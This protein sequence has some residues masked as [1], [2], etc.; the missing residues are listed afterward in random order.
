MN[1]IDCWSVTT[2]KRRAVRKWA[3]LR[4]AST[5]AVAS[6]S[7]LEYRISLLFS[8]FEK[9]RRGGFVDLESQARVHQ[10]LL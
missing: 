9:R 10:F 1:N 7:T 6:F 8:V 2:V 5:I 4:M 3:H